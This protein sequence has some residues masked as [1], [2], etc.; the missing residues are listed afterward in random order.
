MRRRLAVFTLAYDIHALAI[1]DAL[2]R[3]HPDTDLRIIETNQY[4][5]RGGMSWSSSGTH[6]YLTDSEG[7]RIPI[8][9]LRAIWW[10]RVNSPLDL[11][12][13]LSDAASEL[14]ANDWRAATFGLL[15]TSF[16][17]TWISDPA[18]TR[19]AENK[20]VQIQAAQRA[21]L[22]VPATLVSQDPDVVKEFCR[23]C[24]KVIVKSVKGSPVAPAY[25]CF[26]TDEVLA[27]DDA[28]RLAPAIYQEYVPGE[29]HIRMHVFGDESLSV[30]IESPDM[31]WRRDLSRVQLTPYNLSPAIE[32]G[33]RT[34]IADLGLV[35]GVVDLKIDNEG[36][37][38]WLEVNP[39][40]QFLF[41]EGLCGV[42]L[43]S[44][45]ARFLAA[46]AA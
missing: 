39:Q 1:R 8:D 14:V 16:T 33:V 44:M 27:A 18:A 40:G 5:A 46:K 13:G 30:L 35:M 11:P 15:L 37:P 45:F 3:E 26:V 42:P 7:E 36:E 23:T 24:S 29:R 4:A 6:G 38:V 34:V 20:L 12:V 43:T 41:V 32:R 31:D 19:R 22:R 10:R 17:G 28:I 2:Q 9:E 25:T 21:G